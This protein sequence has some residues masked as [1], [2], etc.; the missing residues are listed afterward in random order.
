M[1]RFFA[2]SESRELAYLR[3]DNIRLTKNWHECE[4][5]VLR[6]QEQIADLQRDLQRANECLDEI[7]LNSAMV[8]QVV[9][10]NDARFWGKF[11]VIDGGR[12]A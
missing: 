3:R 1:I 9:A 12:A 11:A 6:Q 2:A 7:V 8:D 4:R 5:V 10:D